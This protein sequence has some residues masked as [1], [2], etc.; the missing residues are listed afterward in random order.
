MSKDFEQRAWRDGAPQSITVHLTEGDLAILDGIA[1]AQYE[2]RR[3]NPATAPGRPGW[4]PS[5]TSAIRELLHGQVAPAGPRRLPRVPMAEEASRVDVA[6][7]WRAEAS[8]RQVT[9]KSYLR[10]RKRQ[11]QP[12]EPPWE[13]DSDSTPEPADS[14]PPPTLAAFAQELAELAE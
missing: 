14:P 4:T 12:P 2:A 1:A 10:P 8:W 11:P 13:F 9:P 5:R 6:A 7:F 3:Y